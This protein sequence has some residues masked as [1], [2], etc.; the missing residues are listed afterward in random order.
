MAFSR[1]NFTF[2]F[3]LYI[4][5]YGFHLPIFMEICIYVMS[6]MFMKICIYVML[7]KIVI[8]DFMKA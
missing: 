8:P 5:K 4:V 3:T 7:F 2:T 6:K 1:V